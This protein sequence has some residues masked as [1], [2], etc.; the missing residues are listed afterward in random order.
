VPRRKKD[1]LK[2]FFWPRTKYKDE[3]EMKVVQHKIAD[4]LE[5]LA[6]KK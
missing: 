6:H 3:E 5:D 4:V 2:G 1:G